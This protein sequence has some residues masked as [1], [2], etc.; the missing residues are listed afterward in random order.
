MIKGSNRNANLMLNIPIC[1]FAIFIVDKV[2]GHELTLNRV[3]RADMGAYLCIAANGIPPA[4]SKQ[5]M[6]HVQCK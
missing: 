1:P 4:V 5:I 3:T 6:V 2:K